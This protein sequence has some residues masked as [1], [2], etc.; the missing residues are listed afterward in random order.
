M[1]SNDFD[2][3]LGG[4][5]AGQHNLRL[6][7]KLAAQGFPVFPCREKS[8]TVNGRIRKEKSPATRYGFKDAT[9]NEKQIR[10]WWSRRPYALVGMPTGQASGFAVLDLDRHTEESD[11][12][13]ALA[14]MGHK[15]SD[16]TPLR[17]RTANGGLHLYFKHVDGVTNKDRH[18]P[19]GIDVRAEGGFVIAPG[20]RFKDGRFYDELDLSVS[21]PSF[22]VEMMPVERDGVT[23]ESGDKCRLNL[24]MDEIRAYMQDYPNDDDTS[25]AHWI[26]V[27]AS[28]HHEATAADEGGEYRPKSEQQAICQIALDWTAK[29][30]TYATDEHLA[31]AKTDFWSFRETPYKNLA[32]FRSIAKTV[33]SIRLD[34]EMESAVDDFDDVDEDD[35]GDDF[36]DLLGGPNADRSSV[37]AS[38]SEK[39]VREE[40]DDPAAPKHIRAMNKKHALVRFNAKTY[41]VDIAPKD[42]DDIISLGDEKSLHTAYAPN[43]IEMTVPDPNTGKSK[44]KEFTWS[45]LWISSPYRRFYPRGICFNPKENEKGRLNLW[46]GWM[47]EPDPTGNCDLLLKHIKEVL[48]CGVEEHYTAFLD[49][50]AHMIQRPWERPTFALVMRGEMGAGKDTPFRY[51]GEM[52]GPHYITVGRNSD[53][54]GRFNA[55]L[56]GKILVHLQEGF[57]AGN[58]EQQNYMKFLLDSPKINIENKGVN[59]FS[60]RAHH[61]TVISSNED[62]VAPAAWGERRYFILDVENTY[63]NGSSDESVARSKAYFDAIDHQMRKQR[64]LGKFFHFLMTRDISKFDIRRPPRTDALASQVLEGLENVERWWFDVLESGCI[65]STEQS[66]TTMREVWERD[67]L[68]K[69]TD[70]L[71]NAYERWRSHKRYRA[72]AVSRSKFAREMRRVCPQLMNKQ[73]RCGD[74]SARVRLTILPQL[75]R[76][77]DEFSKLLGS[78]I[79]WDEVV[80]VD[81]E[82]EGDDLG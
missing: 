62:W 59:I 5:D 65:D 56:M 31:Q 22:P 39:K 43:K 1:D 79:E 28:L 46:R 66:D 61:R 26:G 34:R 68:S 70:D 73:V 47:V 8:E 13:L 24:S 10:S 17:A 54:S 58:R 27:I 51:M 50:M 48:C 42:S 21:V 4:V 71:F 69:P 57:Y 52:M 19:K 80:S 40:W 7:L 33:R 16:L 14:E 20:S 35:L 74:N 11:G 37:D 18:L 2:D 49:F 53:I 72:E 29:N 44:I 12:I 32:T 30:P 67:W 3:L 36:D 78:T 81:E 76:C 45:Q 77:R 15:P 6:A 38:A 60:T 25:R 41:V 9:T 63:A 64:G 55:H 75:S 23:G 82:D